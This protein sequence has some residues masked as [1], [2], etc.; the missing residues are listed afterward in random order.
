MPRLDRFFR[1]GGCRPKAHAG[2]L[3]GVATWVG[4]HGHGRGRRR[5]APGAFGEQPFTT[6]G[7]ALLSFRRLSAVGA[8]VVCFGQGDP[9]TEDADAAMRGATDPFA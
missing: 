1:A 9:V 8:S 5:A 7:E 3:L 2:T 6:D 4:R